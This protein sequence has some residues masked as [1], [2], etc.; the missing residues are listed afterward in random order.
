VNAIAKILTQKETTAEEIVACLQL[1]GQDYFNNPAKLEMYSES[2]LLD[3]LCSVPLL[4]LSEEFGRGL[5]YQEGKTTASHAVFVHM[6]SFVANFTVAAKDIVLAQTKAIGFLAKYRQRV[7][8]ILGLW[9]WSYGAQIGVSG[10]PQEVYTFAYLEELQA[11]LSFLR[12]LSM[13]PATLNG[14]SEQLFHRVYSQLTTQTLRFISTEVYGQSARIKIGTPFRIFDLFKPVSLFEE[15]L[16]KIQLKESISYQNFRSG[17]SVQRPEADSRTPASQTISGSPFNI[18]TSHGGASSGLLNFMVE[19][20]LLEIIFL[21]ADLFRTLTFHSHASNWKNQVTSRERTSGF[22]VTLGG[23]F[24]DAQVYLKNF[25]AKM[26]LKDY[27]AEG[28]WHLML[29]K[30]SEVT[31]LETRGLFQVQTIYSYQ[32]VK[33]LVRR[34]FELTIYSQR[35]CIKCFESPLLRGTAEEI[36][37][38]RKGQD[39]SQ[40]IVNEFL[41]YENFAANPK[42]SVNVNR[43]RRDMSGHF[44]P[45]RSLNPKQT[46]MSQNLSIRTDVNQSVGVEAEETHFFDLHKKVIERLNVGHKWKS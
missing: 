11:I 7:E 29:L 14:P 39:E 10:F 19:I 24:L 23:I 4:D 21:A 16:Q 3:S 46:L 5:F 2:D 30:R 15:S 32:E 22:Y 28:V 13:N 12:A 6:V 17:T 43:S 31:T 45:I 36:A 26:S 20:K 38:I 8:Q 42:Q 37:M 40:K 25:L 41:R 34:A 9:N 35:M 44:D 33:N 18:I 1:F 27:Y